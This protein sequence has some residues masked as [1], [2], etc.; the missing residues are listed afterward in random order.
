[1]AISIDDALCRYDSERRP[2]AQDTAMG[3]RR[4]GARSTSKGAYRLMTPMALR[5]LGVDP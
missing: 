3:A 4:D 2:H 5:P 1:M